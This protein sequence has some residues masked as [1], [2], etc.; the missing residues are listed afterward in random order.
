MVLRFLL[1]TPVLFQDLTPEL[2]RSVSQTYLA[3]G[4]HPSYYL[5]CEST[6]GTGISTPGISVCISC[7]HDRKN[8]VVGGDFPRPAGVWRPPPRRALCKSGLIQAECLCFHCH[9]SVGAFGAGCRVAKELAPPATLL[10]PG[11]SLSSLEVQWLRL[12]APRAGALG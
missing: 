7:V 3:S 4:R 5:S 1:E 11:P 2:N 9:S 8:P 12:H 10:L 6:S